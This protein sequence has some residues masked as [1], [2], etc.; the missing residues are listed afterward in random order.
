MHAVKIISEFV[1]FEGNICALVM[2]RHHQPPVL[3][4]YAIGQFVDQSHTGRACN[5]EHFMFHSCVNIDDTGTN[6]LY[7]YLTEN[8]FNLLL[9]FVYSKNTTLFLF[10]NNF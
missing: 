6:K 5:R 2:K 4:R 7:R 3:S 9:F 10:K 1:L 8:I